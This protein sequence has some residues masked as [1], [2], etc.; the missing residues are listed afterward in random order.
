MQRGRRLRRLLAKVQAKLQRRQPP[1]QRIV[2]NQRC[3]RAF[4]NG[5]PAVEDDDAIGADDRRQP[6]RNDERRAPRHE[7]VEGPSVEAFVASPNAVEGV[8][9]AECCGLPCC[10]VPCCEFPCC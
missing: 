8:A 7:P 4:G 5:H 1:V 3:V 6:V 10:D 2:A 9:S